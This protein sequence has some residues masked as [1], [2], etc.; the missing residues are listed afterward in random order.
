M[1][2]W[3]VYIVRCADDSLYTGITKDVRR[4]VDEHNDSGMLGARYTRGRQPVELVY[5]ETVDSRSRATRR[6]QQIRR[7]GR[8]Q[9]QLLI[10]KAKR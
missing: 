8:G 10:D 9:K 2:S 5:Q 7:L 6:E 4:R 3:Y 1:E